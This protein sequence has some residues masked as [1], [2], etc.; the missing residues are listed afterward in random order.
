M[1]EEQVK[2]ITGLNPNFHAFL[3]L[4]SISTPSF[5]GSVSETSTDAAVTVQDDSNNNL[6]QP[7]SSNSIHLNDQR[8]NSSLTKTS[9]VENVKHNSP[10]TVGGGN[11]MGRTASSQRVASLEHLQKRIRGDGKPREL[12]SNGNKC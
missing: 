5:D 11:K 6:C 4:S 7:V 1:A 2:R 12:Q 10:A 3:N 8:V 9:S